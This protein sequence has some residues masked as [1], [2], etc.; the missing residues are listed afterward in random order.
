MNTADPILQKTLELCQVILEQPDTHSARQRIETF[1]SNDQARAQYEGVMAKGQ[2]LQQRQQRSQPL[3]GAEISEF[4]KERDALLN[5]PVARGFL[6]AQDTLHQ[7]HQSITKY[8][9]KTLELGRVP[10]EADFDSCGCDSGCGCG[11]SH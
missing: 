7:V 11:H 2:A 8:V 10:S 9:T 4:E 1:L 3:T 5:N 6:D